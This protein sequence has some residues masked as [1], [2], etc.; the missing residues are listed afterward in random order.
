MKME[1][2]DH[3][4][5]PFVLVPLKEFE[6]LLNTAEML[7]DIRAFD[8]AKARKEESF[9]Q[10]VADA[11]A[12]DEHPVR[13]FRHYRGLTQQQLATKARITRPYLTEI[14]TGKK[15]GS[16]TVLKAIAKALELE[17]D[18]IA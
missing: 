2:I 18:D 16:I 6:R 17:V 13:V 12:R 11:L 1:R 10:S 8:A 4:G 3:K 15:Q 7:E 14:E 9:P 5:K